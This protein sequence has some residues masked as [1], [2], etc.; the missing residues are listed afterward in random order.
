ML[1]SQNLEDL[2]YFFSIA[3]VLALNLH[4]EKNK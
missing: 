2:I 4:E 1:R 3:Y